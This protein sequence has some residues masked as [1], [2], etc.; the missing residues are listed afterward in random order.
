MW[1]ATTLPDPITVP[2]YKDTSS[3]MME[4]HAEVIMSHA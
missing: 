4:E 1:L 3:M 2:A